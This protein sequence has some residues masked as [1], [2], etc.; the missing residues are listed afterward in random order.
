MNVVDHDDIHNL[1]QVHICMHRELENFE[2]SSLEFKHGSKL[3]KLTRKA[4]ELST[5]IADRRIQGGA[6]VSDPKVSKDSYFWGLIVLCVSL[7]V[8]GLMIG[9]FMGI[10]YMAIADLENCAYKG[11]CVETPQKGN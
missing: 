5:R 11:M 7:L 6:K 8:I 1:H 2:E 4:V 10:G 3:S 9:A